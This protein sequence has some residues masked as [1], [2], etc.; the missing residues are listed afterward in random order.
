MFDWDDFR[1]F[2]AAA[3]SGSFGSA[4]ARLNIDAAT[5]G[6]RVARLETAINATLVVRSKSGL[7]LTAAGAR[8]LEIGMDAEAAMEAVKHA[9]R[10]DAVSGT[11][12]I[13]VAEGFGTTIVAPALADLRAQRPGL[14]IELAAHAGFLSPTRREVD[15]AVT[16]SV[17][18]H[19]RLAVEPLTDYQ[20][21]LYASKAFLKRA[22]R[23]ETVNDLKSFDIVSY[24]DDLLYAPELRYL[25]EI[26]PRLQPALSSSSIRAQREIVL[27][28]GG[29]G[30]LP[31][32][33][34]QGLERVLPDAVLLQR[35]FWM[36]SHRDVSDTARV[37]A[38]KRWMR[39][40][41]AKHQG[42][43]T[44]FKPPT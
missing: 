40:L 7:Q 44:P 24:V 16:L 17:P 9:G 8:L 27:S 41:V 18:E 43:L 2:I 11:V 13:S 20:L 25:D 15:M 22:G 33:M 6:R 1:I 42:Q 14:R 36:S 10:S 12:R 26:S 23:P 19:T 3:R 39:D 29:I 34:A 32:F 4:A 28:D 38:V 37:R 30:I 35:R 5:V 31:C 21:A